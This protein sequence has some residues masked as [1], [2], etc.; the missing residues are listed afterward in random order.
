MLYAPIPSR[1]PHILAPASPTSSPPLEASALGGLAFGIPPKWQAGVDRLVALDAPRRKYGLPHL[2]PPRLG[3][4][5]LVCTSGINGLWRPNADHGSSEDG[6]PNDIVIE[7]DG[8]AWSDEE[9]RLPRDEA[10]AKEWAQRRRL[11]RQARK[12][13]ATIGDGPAP[14]GA[15]PQLSAQPT[16]GKPPLALYNRAPPTV[17]KS[18]SAS[19]QGSSTTVAAASTSSS[20]T[21][22]PQHL[23]TSH[24]TATKTVSPGVAAA[25]QVKKRPAGSPPPNPPL[26]RA[27]SHTTDGRASKRA[28]SPA[29]SRKTELQS[30]V[31]E[32]VSNV[33][34]AA[35]TRYTAQ[36]ALGGSPAQFAAADDD[37]ALE[38][39]LE[40][41]GCTQVSPLYG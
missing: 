33:D 36:F 23:V 19:R 41:F 22:N 5:Q 27:S 4:P 32:T 17:P 26:S 20:R 34:S 18:R 2:R 28:V 25:Q 37:G 14:R 16:A 39:V 11:R 7:D 1:I 15:I 13:V 9:N 6:E 24:F 12:A 38:E 35:S 3:L 30:L 8:L 29:S 10:E 40:E 21:L 31:P